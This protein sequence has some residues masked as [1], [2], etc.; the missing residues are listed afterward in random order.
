M[1]VYVYV[2][3]CVQSRIE[4][5]S[6]FKE[7][8]V[9]LQGALSISAAYSSK[10]VFV[11]LLPPCRLAPGQYAWQAVISPAALTT[12][13]YRKSVGL[14]GIWLALLRE[15]RA[16]WKAWAFQ[17]TLAKTRNKS[18]SGWR[19]QRHKSGLRSYLELL[20]P[21]TK[22]CSSACGLARERQDD[23]HWKCTC[24][25]SKC[26]KPHM[27]L[28]KV[29]STTA[30]GA[31]FCRAQHRHRHRG[32]M[33]T[34]NGSDQCPQEQQL[35]LPPLILA[36]WHR[37]LPAGH[38]QQVGQEHHSLQEFSLLN[39]VPTTALLLLRPR[40]WNCCYKT[41]PVTAEISFSISRRFW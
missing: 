1:S 25:H 5:L 30:V 36:R 38:A 15:P 14:N 21:L 3:V 9:F 29:K 17:F 27:S 16:P 41:F 8:S 31:Q 24:P 26:C 32:A 2:Y 4:I 10:G 23:L 13:L 28:S 18:F 37:Q 6:K 40:L 11:S 39:S 34:D 7:P 20:M 19:F 12:L 33:Q 35:W 22:L